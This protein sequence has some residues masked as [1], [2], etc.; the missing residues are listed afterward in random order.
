MKRICLQSLLVLALAVQGAL[1]AAAVAAEARAAPSGSRQPLLPR[2]KGSGLQAR[3]ARLTRALGL[4]A[5]QQAALRTALQDQRQQV[6]RIWNDESVS[7]ADR[8]AATR[9][10]STL[11]ADRIRAMLNEDQRKKYDPPPQGDPGKT[12]GSAHVEDWV[13]AERE[14]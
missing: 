9:K 1:P 3:V 7:A 6:Q 2:S 12:I 10:V 5:R 8:I 11:T 14:R 4:D 13:N